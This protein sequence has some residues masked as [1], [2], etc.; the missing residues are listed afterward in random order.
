M[1]EAE[2]ATGIVS[3]TLSGIVAVA[4]G[5]IEGSVSVSMMKLYV[6][7][8]ATMREASVRNRVMI[9]ILKGE[10]KSL[11]NKH[12]KRIWS[13]EGKVEYECSC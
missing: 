11:R 13:D 1:A 7:S 6:G 12:L 8:C 4:E 5:W 3:V 10:W 2:V 9:S